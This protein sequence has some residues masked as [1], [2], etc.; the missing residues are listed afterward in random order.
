MNELVNQ[1]RGLGDIVPDQLAIGKV[2]R[3]LGSKFNYVVAAIEESN[4]L[5][6]LTMD[7]LSGSLQAHEARMISQIE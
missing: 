3:S 2:L 5:T 6:K 4:D 1:I 7:E